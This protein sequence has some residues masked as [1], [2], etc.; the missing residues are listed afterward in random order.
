[1]PAAVRAQI[2][3]QRS[4]LAAAEVADAGGRRAVAE[5]FVAGFR[6]IAWIAAALAGASALSGLALENRESPPVQ[7]EERGTAW[8]SEP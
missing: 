1:M 7:R 5:S 8:R 3:L 2:D 4:R 6:A